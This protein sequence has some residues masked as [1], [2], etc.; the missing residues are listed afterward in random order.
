MIEDDKRILTNK[1]VEKTSKVNRIAHMQLETL[2][3]MMIT[4]H[5]LNGKDIEITTLKL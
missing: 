3:Q 4:N 5:E 2:N 1:L